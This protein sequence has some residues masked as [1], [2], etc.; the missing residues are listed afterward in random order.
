MVNKSYSSSSQPTCLQPTDSIEGGRP[1]VI[2]FLTKK[3]E[4]FPKS[5]ILKVYNSHFALSIV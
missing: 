1:G 2:A 4:M 3:K 5:M